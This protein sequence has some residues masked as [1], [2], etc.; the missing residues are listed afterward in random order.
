MKGYNY[1]IVLFWVFV[2]SGCIRDDGSG[3]D[4]DRTRISFLYYGDVPGQCRFLEKSDNVTL[5]VYDS[6]GNLVAIHTKSG[7]DLQAYK[8]INLNLPDGDYSLVAWTNLT[9]GT[10][11]RDTEQLSKAVLGS[12]AYYAG[13]SVIHHENDRVYFATK[14]ITVVQSQF[15]DEKLLFSQAHIPLRIHV[16]GAAM[17]TTR[18]TAPIEV[19][20]ENLNPQMGFDGVSTP[21]LKGVYRAQ[22]SYDMETGDYTACVNAFRFLNDNDIQLKLSNSGGSVCYKTVGLADFMNEHSI[23]VE[24]K[25]EAEIAIR[26][27]FNNTSVDVA[28]WEEEDVDPIQK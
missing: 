1:I 6:G 17:P 16:T 5:L 4:C 12:A 26:F 25:D 3:L 9:D 15:R 11:L 22:L 18:A 14:K 23:S 8:G 2:L 28:P 13:N 21:I 7:A 24:D 27:R 10:E 19:D 20:I